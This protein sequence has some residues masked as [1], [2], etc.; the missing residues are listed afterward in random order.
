MVKLFFAIVGVAE[1]LD[2]VNIADY[3][4]VYA[5]KKA[6]YPNDLKDIDASKLQLF[7]AKKDGALQ[8][9]SE[10]GKKLRAGETTALIEELT[11]KDKELDPT[12]VFTWSLIGAPTTK[13]IHLLVVIPRPSRLAGTHSENR[14]KRWREL[15][16][17]FD[18]N[19]KAEMNNESSFSND[20]SSP[21]SDEQWIEIN[22]V[23][24]YESY[25]QKREPI[26]ECKL[27][28]LVKYMKHASKR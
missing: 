26:P 17:I 24:N 13:T 4:S 8:F 10:D 12:E 28:F 2:E 22:S 6:L 27:K 9:H 20:E 16:E 19:K 1:S 23:L 21:T 14:R 7:L 25:E 5:L 15:N 3:T 18:K 11:H